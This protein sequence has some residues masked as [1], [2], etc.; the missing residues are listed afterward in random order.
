MGR[1]VR[2]KRRL[3]GVTAIAGLAAL[4]ALFATASAPAAHY[5][6]GSIQAGHKCLEMAGSG[7]PVKTE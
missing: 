1:D 4:T 2:S 7:D 6:G 3:A 5:G